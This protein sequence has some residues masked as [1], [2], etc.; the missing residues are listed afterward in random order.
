MLSFQ[1]TFRNVFCQTTNIRANLF[2]NQA[3]LY[4][5][6]IYDPLRFAR[7]FVRGKAYGYI[8]ES[9]MFR[10]LDQT[11]F[12]PGNL[13]KSNFWGEI[14]II[15]KLAFEIKISQCTYDCQA[16][17]FIYVNL[18]WK[19][20]R[21]SVTFCLAV[22]GTTYRGRCKSLLCAEIALTFEDFLGCGPIIPGKFMHDMIPLACPIPFHLKLMRDDEGARV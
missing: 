3:D 12:F 11:D 20:L 2:K 14:L 13:E 1:N 21:K 19:E 5:R 6:V 4:W 18:Q 9:Q 7:K 15:K 17:F 16:S 10:S 8:E 22:E